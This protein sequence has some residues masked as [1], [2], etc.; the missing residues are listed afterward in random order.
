MPE[1][2][3]TIKHAGRTYPLKLNT[4]GPA[5][6]FKQSV[7]EV[8]GVPVDRVKI[9]VKGGV[10]KD[11]HD[12]SKAGIKEGQTLMVIGAAGPLPKAPEKPTVFLEDMDDEDLAGAVSIGYRGSLYF[13]IG[14]SISPVSSS[15]LPLAC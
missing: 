5:I 4:D 11:D 14:L 6:D 7:Y 12:W 10:L 8:T 1:Y 13:Q 3:V 15:R 2:S 9:M